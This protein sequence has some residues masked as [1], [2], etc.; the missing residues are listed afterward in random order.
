MI[1]LGHT[2]CCISRHD[3]RVFAHHAFKRSQVDWQVTDDVQACQA[4]P[5]VCRAG[6]G[7]SRHLEQCW[8][9]KGP[10]RSS[11]VNGLSQRLCQCYA[12]QQGCVP[13][14]SITMDTDH[15]GRDSPSSRVDAC[16]DIQPMAAG[17][18][19]TGKRRGS[20]GVQVKD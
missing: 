19:E 5:S 9:Q 4:M 3:P 2:S 1:L 8:R 7:N 13:S 14:V 6:A 18:L 10:N 20:P 16:V 11:Q 12:M 17:N 15:V